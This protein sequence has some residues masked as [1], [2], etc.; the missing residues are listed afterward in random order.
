MSF[1]SPGAEAIIRTDDTVPGPHGSVRIRRYAAEPAAPAAPTFVWIHGGSFL[2][3]DLDKV[4]TDAVARELALAGIPVVTVDYRLMRPGPLSWFPQR[5]GA[6]SAIRYPVPV[7]DVIA[8]VRH[9]QRESPH[10]VVLGGASAGG[11][12]AGGATTHLA[13]IGGAPLRGVFLAYGLMHAVMP[14]ISPA[15]K[16]RLRGGRKIAHTAR[17]I[18]LLNRTY[19]G[20]AHALGQPD[21]FPGGHDLTGFPPTLLIDADRDSLRASG[22][23]FAQELQEAGIPTEY[24]VVAEALH[25][26]FDR[27]GDPAFGEGITLLIRWI[28]QLP[29]HRE[30][31]AATR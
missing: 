25:A 14:P 30:M 7:D 11:T 13:G 12:L 20:S 31:P 29:P 8:A 4:E 16:A 24:H 17:N 22:E 23:S 1:P 5:W 10:G 27:P 19:A 3:G 18:D 15:L 9:I 2:T 6:R 26:F 21:A 28:R